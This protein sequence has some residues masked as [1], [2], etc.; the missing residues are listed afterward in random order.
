MTYWIFTSG[1]EVTNC[2]FVSGKLVT[3][4]HLPHESGNELTYCTF[5]SG[6]ELTTCTFTSGNEVTS[7]ML[8]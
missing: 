8:P 7:W 3:I 1:N 6:K 5:T 4:F 2:T